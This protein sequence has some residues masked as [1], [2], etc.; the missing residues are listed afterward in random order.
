M[1]SILYQKGLTDEWYT[2]KYIIDALGPFD[3]DPCSPTNRPFDTA[4][5]HLTIEENGLLRGWKGRIWLNPPYSNSTPFMERLSKHG[6]GIALIPARVETE[7]FHKY[8]W[9]C[10]DSVL[11]PIGRIHFITSNVNKS[12]F[13]SEETKN[14]SISN[15]AS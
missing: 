7:M 13:I 15:F 1:S 14:K 11:F 4:R 10:A 6:N 2:P 8:V 5:I 3:L 9:N 12:R